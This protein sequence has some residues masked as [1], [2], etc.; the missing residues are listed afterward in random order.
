MLIKIH[1]FILIK[2]TPFTQEKKIDTVN[3]LLFACDKF[4]QG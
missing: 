4:L 2:L 3:Q 1:P